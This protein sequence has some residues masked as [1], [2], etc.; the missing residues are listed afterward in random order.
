MTLLLDINLVVFKMIFRTLLFHE[1]ATSSSLRLIVFTR[2]LDVLVEC[3]VVLH[4]C[5][6]RLSRHH[7]VLM[8]KIT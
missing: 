1:L 5:R 4:F 6:I 7:K 2:I 3:F 8:L